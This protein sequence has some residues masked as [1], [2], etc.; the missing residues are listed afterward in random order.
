MKLHSIVDIITNSSSE[1]FTITNTTLEEVEEAVYFRPPCK[2]CPYL[3]RNSG[4][5]IQNYDDNVVEVYVDRWV[6][7]VPGVKNRLIKKFGDSNVEQEE[8]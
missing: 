6:G 1:L 5:R 3:D 2:D 8:Y 4:I 7:D